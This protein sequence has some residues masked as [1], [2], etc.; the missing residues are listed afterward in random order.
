MLHT[1]SNFGCS[2]FVHS[3][4]RLINH[5]RIRLDVKRIVRQAN[6]GSDNVAWVTHGVHYTIVREGAFNQIDRIR[7]EPGHSHN[8]QAIMPVRRW[9]LKIRLL[10]LL[11]TTNRL[12][13]PRPSSFL[14][15]ALDVAAHRHFRWKL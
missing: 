12:Q 7:L 9:P 1:G 15:E 6:G 2:A 8:Q 13:P 5:G 11:C 3:L 14:G 4:Y 10:F